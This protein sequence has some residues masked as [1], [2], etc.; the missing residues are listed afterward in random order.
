MVK[1]IEKVLRSYALPFWNSMKGNKKRSYWRK[2]V[3]TADA[4]GNYLNAPNIPG[5]FQLKPE[6]FETS[7]QI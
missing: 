3:K 5:K 4:G 6:R 7:D 1:G 2:T